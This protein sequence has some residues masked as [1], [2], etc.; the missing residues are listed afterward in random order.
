MMDGQELMEALELLG[1][2]FRIKGYPLE[3]QV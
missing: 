1:T 3:V 2:A